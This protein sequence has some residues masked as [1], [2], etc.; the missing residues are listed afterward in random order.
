MDIK[1]IM[2]KNKMVCH[3]NLIYMEEITEVIKKSDFQNFED[4]V[5]QSKCGNV[6]ELCKSEKNNSELSKRYISL[7]EIY[8][9]IGEVKKEL[10]K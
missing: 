10:N 2:N 3:C 7:I 8:Q 1:E 6:C 5:K 9:K 4:F